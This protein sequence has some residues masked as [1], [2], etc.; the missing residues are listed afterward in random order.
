M[1]RFDA[2]RLHRLVGRLADVPTALRRALV[3]LPAGRLADRAAGLMRWR[4][5]LL[6]GQLP[7]VEG[8][9]PAG[10]A[11]V[12]VL[13]GLRDLGVHQFCRD[14]PELV[15]ELLADVIAG[16]RE[17]EE[18]FQTRVADELRA[19]E[20]ARREVVDA[21]SSN[22]S[23]RVVGETDGDEA[24]ALRRALQADPGVWTPP[25]QWAERIRLW[26]AITAVF[27]ELGSELGLGWDLS[28]GLL[29]HVGWAEL[30]RLRLL[31]QA[32]PELTEL[33]RQ[34]GRLR[35]G[36][37]PSDTETVLEAIS[38]TEEEQRR[39]RTPHAPT[40][41]RGIERSGSLARM[42]PSEAALLSLP[43]TR[44]LWHA[45]RAER[46]LM[47]YRV[48]GVAV[49][50][51]A[52][53]RSGTEHRQRPRAKKDRGP[54]IVC[55]DTSGSMAGLPERVAKAVVLEAMRVAHREG[56]RLYLYAFSGPGQVA[57]QELDLGPGGVGRL[58]DFLLLSFRGG[59]DVDR[60]LSLALDRLQSDGWTDA[61]VLLVS[62]GEF[63]VSVELK[64]RAEELASSEGA[65]L[66]G[67]LV[68]GS[69]RNNGLR[70]L[71]SD[72]HVFTDWGAVRVA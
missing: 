51:I 68:G 10:P 32:L 59:T 8:A 39:V 54:I 11:A 44:M 41:M 15:D 42:L 2:V 60:P 47:T 1:A 53:E 56:R 37:A 33:V 38:W 58:L 45:R 19:L 7:A 22:P 23:L 3:T 62:D 49:E 14:Q 36:E 9:W 13:A 69:R 71:C 31:L 55:L 63:P 52:F 28:Q 64:H 35:S 20:E 26:S 18:Q 50:R 57:E 40:E 12:R 67:L 72:V 17:G 24:E 66:H 25:P 65:R 5:E 43:A 16:L 6:N 46:A 30:T 21:L 34:L 27:G 29:A 48:E 4:S 70:E 61:D